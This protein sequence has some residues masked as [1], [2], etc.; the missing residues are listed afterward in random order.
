MQL[1]AYIA[2]TADKAISGI[3]AGAKYFFYIC[4]EY[5]SFHDMLGLYFP[6]FLYQGYTALLVQVSVINIAVWGLQMLA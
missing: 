5:T 2:T 1:M 6:D 4:E 3:W